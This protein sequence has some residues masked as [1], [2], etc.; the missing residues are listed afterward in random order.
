M[1]E[2]A[3]I[4]VVE[5]ARSPAVA[6]VIVQALKFEGIPAYVGGCLL[7]DEFAISQMV[8]GLNCVDI[9]VPRSCLKEAKKILK[10]MK[11]AGK[12]LDEEGEKADD[13]PKG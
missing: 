4:V 13:S 11:D 12:L 9:Q 2:E 1:G 6:S 7:Q 3:D 8:L 10:T 5:T